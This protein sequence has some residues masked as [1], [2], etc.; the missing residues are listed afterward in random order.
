MFKNADM[1]FMRRVSLALSIVSLAGLLGACVHSSPPDPVGPKSWVVENVA[2]KTTA[3]LYADAIKPGVFERSSSKVIDGYTVESGNLRMPDK[4]VGALVT[5]RSTDGSLTAQIEQPDKSGLLVINKRGEA[6]FIQYSRQHYPLS[7]AVVEKQKTVPT[8]SKSSEVAAPYVI[9]M[10][11]GYSRNAANWVGGGV[12]AHALSLVENLNL[13]LRNSLVSGV[14]MRLVGTQIVEHDYYISGQT[15]SELRSIFAAG[16]AEF[17][18]D[19][20]YGAF[21]QH[22]GDVAGGIAYISSNLAIGVPTPELFRHEVGHNV[23]GVHCHKDGG[24]SVPYGYGYDNGK[25]GTAQCGTFF[26]YY[27]NPDLRDAF[28]LPLGDAATAD[29]ARVWRENAERLSSYA[30]FT[31]KP[32]TGFR[33]DNN[34]YGSISFVW[35]QSPRA[36]KYEIWGRDDILLPPKKY[37]EFSTLSGT[38][39][40]VP[41]GL[42]PYHLVAVYAGG[43][44]SP[45]SNVVTAKPY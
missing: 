10:F 23:G 38:I 12:H 2:S 25:T 41:S 18:P 42:R 40:N 39:V 37:G 19:M 43:G 6:R 20:I 17:E 26:P 7:D 27:S 11:V 4:S 31:P 13:V 5:V 45:N 9:D 30:H 14:S 24:A 44:R 29:M 34:S 3:E 16:I 8:K 22:E 33:S 15:L 1:W 28:N 36:V 35:D 32:P 21:G